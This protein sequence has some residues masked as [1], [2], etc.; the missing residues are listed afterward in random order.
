MDQHND[1]LHKN[2]RDGKNGSHLEAVAPN[3]IEFPTDDDFT[4]N[5][6]L[7]ELSDSCFRAA[8]TDRF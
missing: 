1:V 2:K 3:M 5:L 6:F 8:G 4:R 7:Q